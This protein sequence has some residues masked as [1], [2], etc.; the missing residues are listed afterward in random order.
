MNSADNDPFTSPQQRQRDQYKLDDTN[1]HEVIFEQVHGT[2][3]AKLALHT[4]W[5]TQNNYQ[6]DA[7]VNM[8]LPEQGISGPFR[9]TSIKHILP[10]KRPEDEDAGQGFVFRPVTGIFIPTTKYF[11][12]PNLLRV[13]IDSCVGF[14]PPHKTLPFRADTPIQ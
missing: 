1:W 7:V 2:S 11:C 13:G 4:D 3:T 9:I 12:A 8:N 14:A 10:Q 5:I 6:L